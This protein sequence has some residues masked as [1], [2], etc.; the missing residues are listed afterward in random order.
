MWMKYYRHRNRWRQDKALLH[1]EVFDHISPMLIAILVVVLLAT[2]LSPAYGQ[3]PQSSRPS[4]HAAAAKQGATADVKERSVSIRQSGFNDFIQGTPGNSGANLYVSR[5]GNIRVINQWDLNQDGYVDVLISNDHDAFE[6]VDALIYWGT[7]AGYTSLLPELWSRRPLA[8][9]AFDLMDKKAHVTRLPAFGGGKSAIADLNCDGYPDIVFCNYIHNYPGLRTAY[10]YWGSADGYDTRHKSELPTNW[11]AG[12]AIADLNGDGYPDLVFANQGVE[13][14]SEDISPET[15]LDSF[16]YWGSATGFDP[17]RRSLLATR[18]AKD[19][20]VADIN[21][22]GWPDI[23]FI[24]DGRQTQDV[25]VFWG[26]ATGYA[27]EHTQSLPVSAPTSI[28]S[29]NINE[30]GYADL[31][32]T[33]AANSARIFWG[34][35]EGLAVQREV[36][37]PTYEAKDSCIG[38]FNHDGFADLAIANTSDGTN[39][40]VQSFVYW[41]SE[42][43]F[44]PARRSELP[45]L[46]ATGV[47]AADLNR[48]GYLDLVFANSNDG[49]TYDIPSFIYWGSALGFAPYLRSDLQGFGAASVN[50]SDLNGDG[51]PDVLLVNRYSGTVWGKEVGTHIFWGNPHHYYS[52]ALM[53]SLPSY[54]CYDTTAA[55]VNDDGFVDLVLSSSTMYWG[56]KEGFSVARREQLPVEP[57]F[58]SSAAD[59][60][61]DGFLDLVFAYS[62]NARQLAAILWGSPTGFSKENKTILP[63]R[64]KRSALAVVAD[65]NQDGHLDLLFLD[66]YL[67][68][69]QIFWGGPEGYSDSRSWASFISAGSLALADLNGDGHLDFVVA[70]GFDPD[71]KSYNTRTRI[72]WGTADG[73][74]SPQGVVELEAYESSECSITD[75]NRDGFLDLILSN[76]MSDS[77]RSLPLF[78][79]WGSTNGFSNTNRT[80]LPAESSCGVQTL[81]LNRDGYPEIIIHNHLKDGVHTI[82]SYIYW[83]GPQGFDK[84]RRTELPNFGPHFSQRTDAGNLYTRRMEEN[85]VSVP[86]EVPAARQA[87]PLFL[88]WKGKEPHGSKLRFQVRSAVTRETLSHAK[89]LGSDGEDSF[90]DSPDTGLRGT[91][92]GDRWLQYRAVFT[93]PDGGE[94]P[95][96]TEVEFRY[97]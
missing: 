62:E 18:G 51:R 60:N 37:L 57:S 31:I 87:P 74:P 48:D 79:Y 36:Q 89:W 69:L 29:G 17:S 3:A 97:K 26:S 70:G 30:D 61:R 35:A 38:D 73:T 40:G 39:S 43:G 55:D 84:R 66:E 63:L 96:L 1:P 22:D 41:G 46:G 32:V 21:K 25:Q 23:A 92:S 68:V 33:T 24:N 14:G 93:S 49:K 10:V 7:D 91:Q 59:L 64:A 76:Y 45:T 82:N 2:T 52:T 65:T 9:V 19:V 78:I 83:N 81:D 47:A 44:S 28:R 20:T 86:L 50:V 16:I 75:L 8:Q 12:V 5:N 42:K 67:G 85:Y 11:A 13:R 6:K 34:G 54:G 95:T 90:Y 71:K 94:W 56:S 58:G 72:F 4:N 80:D 15:P 53:T 88:S 77:T 27:K